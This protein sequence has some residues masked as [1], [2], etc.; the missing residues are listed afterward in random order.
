MPLNA[1]A[2][3]RQFSEAMLGFFYPEV[4][5][6]C[7]ERKAVPAEG[8]VCAE[9]WRGVRFIRPP[10]CERCGLPFEG[11]ITTA[12]QCA[13]CHDTELYFRHA[14]SAVAA[15]GV[16][17]DVIHRY[18]YGRELFFEPF[19]ADLLIREA[20]PVL[21]QE[22]WDSIIP[23]P[24]H[25]LKQREREFNQA[26]RLGRQ[27][28]RATS[29]PLHT[30]VVRRIEP[31]R[32]QTHLG[33]DARAENVRRAF[34]CARGISLRDQR[35]VLVDDVLTTGATTNACARVLREAGAAE[36]CVWT[37]ARGLIQ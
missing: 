10:L 34:A 29:I 9:C 22:R 31:T 16:V 21:K 20:A 15:R 27:L 36:V 17:L 3:I 32:T 23:V 19:L 26:E 6:L 35:L 12:F 13:N 14:R 18:K 37:L 33:R 1:S 28:S 11:E 2:V 8:F 7:G 24:L 25:P 5:Q 30:G 4:C